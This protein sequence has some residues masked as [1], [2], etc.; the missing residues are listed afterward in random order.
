M[1]NE[2]FELYREWLQAG[3]TADTEYAKRFAEESFAD[4]IQNST[5]FQKE[6]MCNGAVFPLAATRTEMK[7]CSISL[8][9]NTEMHLGDVVHVF[10]EDWLCMELYTDELGMTRGEIWM[11]NQLFKYQDVEG[12]V[13]E[14]LAIMDDGSYSKGDEKSI[15]VTDN[16]FVCYMSLDEQSRIL[17]VDKRL[18]K[19]TIL[20][21]YG[22]EILEVG[23]IVWYDAKSKNFGKGSH[24]L[25]FG[26]SDDVYSKEHDSVDLGICD[27]FEPTATT[28][29]PEE[30]GYLFIDGRSSIRIGT[31]RTYSVKAIEA[32]GNTADD[33]TTAEWSVD[34]LPKGAAIAPDGLV[35]RITIPL[36]ETLIGKAF[37]VRC[38]DK[39]GKYQGANVTVEVMSIG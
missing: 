38:T 8:M 17:H 32:S 20:D 1:E 24:L 9:P 37:E 11:C 21:A 28:E 29:V 7:K 14:K 16:Y 30:T 34:N 26:L 3:L 39:N 15:P 35:C 31:S 5:T 19:D 27:Y 23:K 6:A 2:N 36:D 13:I 10:N 25:A 33:F 22:N 18:P 12:N 4:T